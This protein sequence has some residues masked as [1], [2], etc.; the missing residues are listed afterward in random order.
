M[1]SKR[2]N[3]MIA[4]SNTKKPRTNS[5]TSES[6]KLKEI[7]EKVKQ[8]VIKD[9]E[10]AK[11]F[12]M[13][14]ISTVKKA[15]EELKSQLTYL[16]SKNNSLEDENSILTHKIDEEK[17]RA[18]QLEDD[19][20][21]KT[22]ENKEL[23][24]KVDE[25]E[26]RRKDDKQS[27]EKKLAQLK[28]ATEKLKVRFEEERAK[29]SSLKEKNSRLQTRIESEELQHAEHL[30]NVEKI[31]SEKT[32]LTLK[33]KNLESVVKSSKSAETKIRKD[34][35]KLCL[36]LNH[37]KKENKMLR[38]TLDSKEADL[39]ERKAGLLESKNVIE[40]Y[41]KKLQ[42][43]DAENA[44]LEENLA[45]IQ[46]ELIQEKETSSTMREDLQKKSSDLRNKLDTIKILKHEIKE[47]HE[48]QRKL[49]DSLSSKENDFKLKEEENKTLRHQNEDLSKKL[50]KKKSSV[51]RLEAK[52][53]EKKKLLKRC[54][55]SYEEKYSKLNDK[56]K[57]K[58]NSE[59]IKMMWNKDKDQ[60]QQLL[61]LGVAATLPQTKDVTK[62][63]AEVSEKDKKQDFNPIYYGQDI[64]T[65]E[66]SQ[67]KDDDGD[68]ESVIMN[69]TSD[70]FDESL[71]D[72]SDDEDEAS[73]QEVSVESLKELLS[74]ETEAE[75]DQL[76][77]VDNQ[78][79]ILT[80]FIL[81]ELE[82]V[83]Q[84]VVEISEEKLRTQ[85]LMKNI[86]D[87]LI[88]DIE[89]EDQ[90]YEDEDVDQGPCS[91][92]SPPHPK[93]E[94]IEVHPQS[95]HS[96]V[97]AEDPKP[98]SPPEEYQAFINSVTDTVKRA[99]FKYYNTREAPIGQFR[100][101]DEDHFFQLCRAFS[102]QFREELRDSF[103]AYAGD[104]RGL[105]LTPDHKMYIEQ[106]IDMNLESLQQTR[107]NM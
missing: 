96:N 38:V 56:Y 103:V 67:P 17:F 23:K 57:K 93:A 81:E 22:E 24:K 71:L 98:R 69:E 14:S 100:I 29:S 59:C 32:A 68:D 76:N 10:N 70:D 107:L 72:S 51:K 88:A 60:K 90:E 85:Q 73:T 1:T 15:N 58:I 84:S 77:E 3:S 102:R 35:D 87:D 42:E 66:I 91:P 95:S 41:E 46:D 11:Q 8:N 6:N 13:K 28:H 80:P 55:Q 27:Y 25:L 63:I 104:C 82:K 52:V 99:L 45:E 79:E 7:E 49:Q 48:S 16:S 50:K 43:K 4:P 39:E 33:I 92:S 12:A 47:L 106:Q 62:K 78:R 75:E 94:R 34:N 86:L 5:F 18:N 31:E 101:R 26:K 74:Q 83:L 36:E 54:Q 61:D 21:L 2:K 44:A 30:F 89:F 9:I 64:N 53:Y 20:E 40:H 37:L 105:V 65:E 19:V 97:A